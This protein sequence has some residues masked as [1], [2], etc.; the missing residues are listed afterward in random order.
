[1]ETLASRAEAPPATAPA[2]AERL[3]F[4]ASGSEYFRIWIVNLLLSIVTL[5]VYSAWAKVRRNQ[6]FYSCTE[7]AGARFAYH[8][9]AKAI[10]KG[11]ALAGML[12]GIHNVAA[13]WSPPLG[14]VLTLVLVVLA[15]WLVWKSLQ[16]RLYNTSY[17]GLRFHFV[18][19]LRD[20]YL[21]YLW[22]PLLS[23]LSVGL[24]MPFVHQRAKA[25]QHNESRFGAA[26]FSFDAGAASFYKLYGGLLLVCC[27]GLALFAWAAFSTSVAPGSAPAAA[28]EHMV[29]RAFIVVFFLGCLL[30]IMPL[31]STLLQNLIWNHTRLEG[32]RFHSDLRWGRL[33]FIDGSNLLAT[34]FTLGLFA[35]FAQVRLLRYRLESI[36]L[37]PDGG[38][39]D[40]AAAAGAP[41]TALGEGAA[42]VMDFDLSL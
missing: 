15:P 6:Y 13:R 3:R 28:D 41:V 12:L 39:D 11:R 37:L 16:F 26:R 25:Y 32:H 10:F 7:L 29:A 34:I 14:A 2:P 23:I 8:G 1:M 30:L 33:L 24:A 35:P 22:R 21:A 20:A 9:N 17:R 18:G 40:I 4:V 27:I 38:L 42:A 31:F 36:T 19:R 5:G